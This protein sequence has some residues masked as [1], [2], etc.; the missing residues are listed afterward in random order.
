MQTLK[1]LLDQNRFG[2]GVNTDELTA[3]LGGMD[4]FT[5]GSSDLG[6]WLSI[7]SCQTIIKDLKNKDGDGT[8]R[9]LIPDAFVSLI[10]T[11]QPS[12]LGKFFN[13]GKEESGLTDRINFIKPRGLTKRPL[14]EVAPDT[15]LSERYRGALERVTG[16]EYQQGLP[17]TQEALKLSQDAN[18]KLFAWFVEITHKANS[19]RYA[20][21]KGYVGKMDIQV[22]RLALLLE[23]VWWS[24]DSN[25]KEP[26]SEV[27]LESIERA[28]KIGDYWIS[29][30]I[31][32]QRY[33]EEEE[34]FAKAKLPTVEREA[35]KRLPELFTWTDVY[36]VAKEL[37]RT[38]KKTPSNWLYKWYSD[39]II[40]VKEEKGKS[41]IYSLR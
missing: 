21:I 1:F 30:A 8:D 17:N 13:N 40:E 10:G 7:W 32:V 41:K 14:Q 33:F 38:A 24:Y 37:G 29:H 5:N 20:S 6:D 39:K 28:I 19:P 4:K 36:N 22:P 26:P 2:V 35:L 23:L 31:E 27:S 18:K 16:N 3:W 9:T 34:P 25:G 15:Y 11:T 12:N